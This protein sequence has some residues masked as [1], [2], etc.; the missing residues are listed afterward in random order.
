MARPA[1][2]WYRKARDAWYVMHRG[3]QVMLAKGKANRATA[4]RE[5]LRLMDRHDPEV[6]AKGSAMQ[7]CNLFLVY[8][9]AK[10]KP[11][12][13]TGYTHYLPKFCEGIADMD[14]NKVMPKHVTDFLNLHPDWSSTTRYN[15]IRY[16]KRA[17]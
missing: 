8:A 15:A 4:Y 10:L 2:P 5:F 11:K 9:R 1:K 7:A 6:A 17:W 16:I 3:K 12:T 13:L 14:A